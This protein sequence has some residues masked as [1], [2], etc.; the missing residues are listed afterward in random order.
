MNIPQIKEQIKSFGKVAFHYASRFF[1]VLQKGQSLSNPAFW[2][3]VQSLLTLGMALLPL[4]AFMAPE[5]LTVDLLLNLNGFIGAM[6][7]YLTNATSEK[8]GI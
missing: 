4:I 1:I 6:I 2:K 3:H 7:I 8:V 5:W